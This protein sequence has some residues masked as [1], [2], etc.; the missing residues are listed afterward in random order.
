MCEKCNTQLEQLDS[1]HKVYRS[2]QQKLGFKQNADF[3]K[4]CDSLRATITN[5][6][7]LPE[8]SSQ[9][10]NLHKLIYDLA[11]SLHN[12]IQQNY[13]NKKLAEPAKKIEPLIWDL[14]QL[15]ANSLQ[16][17]DHEPKNEPTKKKKK[18]RK[19]VRSIEKDGSELLTPTG[20]NQNPNL[21]TPI[22]ETTAAKLEPIINLSKL[23]KS[24]A[25]TPIQLAFDQLTQLKQ[26]LTQPKEQPFLTPKIKTNQAIKKLL[27]QREHQT[28][29][30]EA[31][32]Q[33]AKFKYQSQLGEI[34]Q[35][36]DYINQAITK[37]KTLGAEISNIDTELPKTATTIWPNE[38][39]IDELK[40][41]L[42]TSQKSLH[43]KLEQIFKLF[44]NIDFNS[45]K[46][47]NE[48]F[49]YYINNAQ[50]FIEQLIKAHS[51]YKNYYQ[52]L[53]TDITVLMRG[54][55]QE[56]S[57]SLGEE[58]IKKLKQ[59]FTNSKI[60]EGNGLLVPEWLFK[61][62]VDPLE[63]KNRIFANHHLIA[64]LNHARLKEIQQ[65]LGSQ[66]QTKGM[67]DK[68]KDSVSQQLKD[69][70][71]QQIII[72]QANCWGLL[73]WLDKLPTQTK[74]DFQLRIEKL[75][76]SLAE[77]QTSIANINT[78]YDA[79]LIQIHIKQQTLDQ[80]QQGIKTEQEKT[81]AKLEEIRTQLSS[82]QADY[83]ALVT[84]IKETYSSNKE[85]IKFEVAKKLDEVKT[86]LEFDS[87]HI[88]YQDQTGLTKLEERL[89][90]IKNDL[91][92]ENLANLQ[93]YS[94]TLKELKL[95][96]S[97]YFTNIKQKARTSLLEQINSITITPLNELPP[98]DNPFFKTL[99]KQ[100]IEAAK[101]LKQA[102]THL[103]KNIRIKQLK[104]WYQDAEAFIP[105]LMKKQQEING[106]LGN[107]KIIEE[108]LSSKQYKTSLVILAEIKQEFDR[109][110]N[111]QASKKPAID[112]SL[113][114]FNIENPDCS[115]AETLDP[116]LPKLHNIYHVFKKVNNK[117]IDRNPDLLPDE[118]YAQHL[119]YEVGA[120][121]QNDHME[122]LS[123][124][125]LP[126]F[127]Q[128]IRIHIIKPLQTLIYGSFWSRPCPATL[129]ATK[130]EACLTTCGQDAIRQ[131]K[132]T[133]PEP[134]ASPQ[135]C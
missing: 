106:E 15:I 42:E 57:I 87:T 125:V 105:Q 126:S 64:L 1:L 99:S 78:E 122:D 47:G 120:H 50:K 58:E 4:Q 3:E 97:N 73:S 104:Q 134:A 13:P 62:K 65:Y 9:I 77:M 93:S 63:Y 46:N 5:N 75:K 74:E 51:D 43:D 111:N 39:N 131:L 89:K 66:S 95:S 10:E 68:I 17:V 24:V 7:E 54:H 76:N 59:P 31:T 92:N 109:I 52:P 94:N 37:I 115:G 45:H 82:A 79:Q 118:G 55:F 69:S 123:E 44:F 2:A 80:Q 71:N 88:D 41:L 128:W 29:V 19:R 33:E 129:F 30:I 114:C 117:Y 21:A 130:T 85:N 81:W 8:H 49:I 121:L 34:I 127:L 116:R 61:T 18:A 53:N 23:D 20:A 56:N 113:P 119:L 35:D 107:A 110:I 25:K 40:K 108:R 32:Y 60:V 16:F 84:D 102:K 36:Y 28:Q 112:N 135:P 67:D 83:S 96:I 90:E 38:S 100:Y 11:K 98:E 70:I 12:L 26:T 101:Q 86:L 124:N 72:I 14:Q 103:S 133:D 132:Q 6:S 91:D 27:K 48:N 22:D